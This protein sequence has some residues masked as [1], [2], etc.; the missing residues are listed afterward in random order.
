MIL[1]KSTKPLIFSIL[2][3]DVLVVV[4]SYLGSDGNI[5]SVLVTEPGSS[6]NLIPKLEDMSISKSKYTFISS[7]LLP[8]LSCGYEDSITSGIKL[9]V[10]IS[11]KS[12]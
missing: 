1:E 8:N 3:P 2:L 6:S 10:Y 5:K 12:I 7:P 9:Y 11:V 4:S